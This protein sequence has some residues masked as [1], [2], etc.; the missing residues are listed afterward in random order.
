M[1]HIRYEGQSL[2][3]QMDQLDLGDLSS[4]VQVRE[5]AAR[6]LSVPVGKFA[7]FAVD[8]NTETGDITLRPNAVFG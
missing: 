7:A 3:F 8:R 5:A 6:F 4:D 2:D 1:L